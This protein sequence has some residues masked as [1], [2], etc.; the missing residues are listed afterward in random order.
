VIKGVTLDFGGT[1]AT[2]NLN[3]TAFWQGLLA[4]LRSLGYRGSDARFEKSR[5]GALDRLTKV[6]RVNREMR[7]EDFIQGLLFKLSLHPDQTT[8][9]Y[10]HRL[11]MASFDTQLVPGV[12]TMLERLS[13][14]YQLAVVSNS[15]SDIPRRAIEKFGLARFFDVTVVSRDLGIRK[16]DPELFHYALSN[17]NVKPSE[18]LHV[19]DSLNQDVV[20]AQ[21]SGMRAVWIDSSEAQ[22][23]VMPDFIIDSILDMPTLVTRLSRVSHERS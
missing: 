6:R 11:Y 8:L 16:P 10:A 22:N 7:L 13:N 4:Y 5:N 2:G 23:T 19:G 20:G 18:A 12:E 21:R 17:L 3:S 14:R 1:L 9:D 15:M